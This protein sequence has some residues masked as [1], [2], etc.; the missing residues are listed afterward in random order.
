MARSIFWLSV[1][2]GVVGT[3]ASWFVLPERVPLHFGGSGV[4]RWGSRTE[5][6]VFFAIAVGSLAL[7][8]WVLAIAM[9]RAPETLLNIPERD[10]VWWLATP[11]RRDKLIRMVV[12]DL[13]A[14]GA[15][16]IVFLVAL[17]AMI[18]REARRSEPALGPFFWVVFSTYM[19]LVLGYS[20][21][22]IV[23]RYRAPRN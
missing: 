6:V 4:D 12:S 8:F 18:I 15:A 14:M 16:T 13:Y 17:Q 23:V 9:P 21:Y 11:E 22:A 10:K 19:A 1:L 5:S 3:S 7:L 2:V 20:G